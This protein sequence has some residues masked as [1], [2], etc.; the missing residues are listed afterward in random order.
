MT[1]FYFRCDNDTK[2][3]YDVAENGDLRTTQ[4]ARSIVR[5]MKIPTKD[6]QTGR[7]AYDSSKPGGKEEYLQTIILSSKQQI[8]QRRL[9][10]YRQFY[11]PRKVRSL[12]MNFRNSQK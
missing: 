4:T 3:Y 12:L 10:A 6:D 9:T 1:N 8:F 5:K 11:Q 2:D 7:S